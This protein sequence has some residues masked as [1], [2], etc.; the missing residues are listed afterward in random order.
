MYGGHQIRKSGG[1]VPECPRVVCVKLST[2]G[3]QLQTNE[4]IEVKGARTASA[5]TV[6]VFASATPWPSVT[7]S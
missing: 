7:L 2:N 3:K 5:E 4:H 1:C 6:T